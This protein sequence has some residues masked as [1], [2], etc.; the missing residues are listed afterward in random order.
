MKVP[1]PGQY[2]FTKKIGEDAPKFKFYIK[3]KSTSEKKKETKSPGPGEYKVIETSKNGRYS[4]S[5]LKSIYCMDFGKSEEVRF[6]DKSNKKKQNLGPGTYE[7]C[8]LFNKTGF[9]FVGKYKS[10]IGKSFGRR[11]DYPFLKQNDLGPGQYKI[12]SDFG[13]PN[14]NFDF[15]KSKG[16]NKTPTLGRSQTSNKTNKEVVKV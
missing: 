4:V 8:Q 11:L 13:Y 5:N 2:E 14:Q 7:P 3:D 1:G 10:S 12:F 15:S 6:D 9:L 16:R